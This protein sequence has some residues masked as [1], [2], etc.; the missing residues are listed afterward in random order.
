MLSLSI[1]AL[2]ALRQTKIA[3]L[4][5]YSSINTGGW[6]LAALIL[7]NYDLI[8]FYLLVYISISFALFAIFCCPLYRDSHALQF[9]IR[10]NSSSS[11]SQRF[12]YLVDLYLLCFTNLPC[13]FV[14]ACSFFSLAGIPPFAGFYTKYLV[15]Y[16]MI[17]EQHY[18]LAFIALASALLSA[19]YYLNIVLHLF[20]K[21][22]PLKANPT[23]F[24]YPINAYIASLSCIMSCALVIRPDYVYL[25]FNLN[26]S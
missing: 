6:I 2:N 22:H 7:Q 18:V 24:I 26:T 19:W 12:I 1:G 5:A 3:R 15:L 16:H 10:L 25:L 13:A 4:I 8:M 11:Q 14:C 23:C 20:V 9:D 17:L 21:T